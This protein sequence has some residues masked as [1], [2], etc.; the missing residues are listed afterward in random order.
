[1]ANR[2][3]PAP[4]EVEPS[5]RSFRLRHLL[6]LAVMGGVAVWLYPR[7]RAAFE[8]H[9]LA[10][11]AADYGAC[12]VG[13]TG[14]ATLR[15]NPQAFSSL[16]RRRLV[17]ASAESFPFADC[18]TLGGRVSGSLDVAR[19][20]AGRADEYLEYGG[21]PGAARRSLSQLSFGLGELKKL[22]RAAWPLERR[23]Y[24]HLVQASS[25]AKEAPHP[26]A[27]TAPAVGRG[28][29]GWR[30][31]YASAWKHEHTR[32]VAIGHA[33]SGTVYE[34]KDGGVHWQ[35]ASTAPGAAERVG[36]C[37]NADAP[38]SFGFE[39]TESGI[40][41]QSSTAEHVVARTRVDGVR[42][43]IT[44][45]CDHD[46]M[47]LA[48]LRG[49]SGAEQ[50][51][52]V[53]CAHAGPCRALPHDPR[54]V[55]GP[56]DVARLGGATV[57]AT[58]R[59][60]IVRVRSSRDEGQ[61]WTPDTVAFDWAAYP[62]PSDVKVPSRLLALGNELWLYGAAQSGQSYPVLYSLDMGTSWYAPKATRFEHARAAR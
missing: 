39:L 24:T 26:V 13:P 6:L 51:D 35:Q 33:S 10:T 60:G 37:A 45:S 15:D 61:S 17:A 42:D 28:L 11:A 23:G 41:V 47:V 9:S 58:A 32:Y 19:A 54:W 50:R 5:E 8:L 62:L 31:A 36:R 43:V 20:H 14:P 3:P 12:M 25:H 49:E 53:V 4:P 46:A 27:P 16:V 18:V 29:P 48:V 7:V 30:S 2:R 56:F 22:A 34:S 52:L 57:L 1:M 44:T 38:R 21:P 40:L 59:A 55:E